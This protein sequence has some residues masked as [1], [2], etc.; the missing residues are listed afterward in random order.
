MYGMEQMYYEGRTE[1]QEPLKSINWDIILEGPKTNRKA[2]VSDKNV[3]ST[4]WR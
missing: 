2:F 4:C 3:G 1:S